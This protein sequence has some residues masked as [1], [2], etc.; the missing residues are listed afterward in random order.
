MR[1]GGG[2]PEVVGVCLPACV[3]VCVCVQNLDCQCRTTLQVKQCR[4]IRDTEGQ[5]GGVR[6]VG[7]EGD[8]EKEEAREGDEETRCGRAE[9][10][11][12]DEGKRG[13]RGVFAGEF[14]TP[15]GFSHT[16][17]LIS[18]V[19]ARVPLLPVSF[20]LTH[21]EPGRCQEMTGREDRSSNPDGGA[22][23]WKVW[24][25]A[26]KCG[27]GCRINMPA[28]TEGREYDRVIKSR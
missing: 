2:L 19:P 13:K 12:T 14:P 4:I 8:G 26:G 16:L 28:L 18:S 11:H 15:G 9:T 10:V 24:T 1:K 20:P 21:W 23:P 17:V 27:T 5:R 3:C 7:K 6:E 25:R 22:Q